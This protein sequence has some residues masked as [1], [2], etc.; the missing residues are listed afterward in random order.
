MSRGCAVRTTLLPA[1]AALILALLSPAS[2]AFADPVLRWVPDDPAILPGTETVLSIV[3]DDTLSV[4]T[5]EVF[6]SYDPQIVT[7][8]GGGPGALFSGHNLFSGFG[9]T[10]PANPGLWH[11]YA[12]ILG[13]DDWT[14]GPGVLFRWIVYGAA[15]GISGVVTVTVRLLPPGGGDYTEVTLPATTV[16][17]TAP[18]AAPDAATSAGVLAVQPNPFNARTELFWTGDPLPGGRLTVF[19]VRGRRVAEL[20]AGGQPA[21]AIA[22][23]DGRGPDGRDLPSGVYTFLFMAP[24]APPQSTRGTLVR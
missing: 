6:V 15:E 9:E 8:S 4:R 5:F 22:V 1:V 18:G 17:V 11:G 19:D 12:V 2:R 16:R 20:D 3:L 24:G 14:V 7:S 13:A 23:W 10:D 21:S